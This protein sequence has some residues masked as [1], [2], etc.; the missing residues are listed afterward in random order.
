MTFRRIALA[1]FLIALALV[2]LL[3]PASN[4]FWITQANYISLYTLVVIGLVLL[5]GIAGLISFGQAAFVGMGAY[6]AA[7]LTLTYGISPWLTVWIGLVVTGVAALVLGWITLRMSGHYLPLATI[8][9]GL[10]LFYLLGNLDALGKYDGLLGIPPINFF[11]IALSTG[12]HFFYLVW[13]IVI[14]AAVAVTHLL[15][16]RAGRALR[17]VK[18]GTTM[19]EAMGVDTFRVKV[20]AFVLAAL[21][22]SISG[23]L[24]AHF[25]RTV[26]PSPFGLNMGIE[27]LF[28]AVLGGVG[29]VW[30]ALVGAGVVQILK[31]QLQVWLPRLMGTSGNYEII[32]F[33]ILL[34][35]VLQYA[36]DGLWA[37]IEAVLPR[38]D[39]K[40][41]WA[42]AEALPARPK[43][44]HGQVVLDVRAV[45]KEFGG[46]VAVNDVSF[47]VKAGEILG[48]IGPNG[49]GKSTTFNLVTGV[50]LATRGEVSLLGRR[51]D[52][53]ASRKIARL[54][55]SR[56]F[57]HVKMIGGMTVLENVALGAHL[58][59]RHGVPAAMLRTDRAEERRLMRE[60]EFQLKR[61]GMGE[62]MHEKAGNL[63]LGQQRLMEIARALAAD[64]TL[65]LL[66]EPAAGLRLKEKEGL[67][68]VLRQLRGEGLSILLVE[69]D[70]DL[71]M[72]LVD[73]VVVMEF[74]TKLIEGTPE[75]VQASPAVRAAYLGTEH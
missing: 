42:N 43:P 2:P 75:E 24:F 19:A 22:A 23:W 69:H 59:G 67:A 31:D 63:A 30:G 1:L 11:G 20:T 58:R 45:R 17:A 27:Y 65:L 34:V 44:P 48:L 16:S 10:S 61:I 74:G 51:I 60:A 38:V 6:T 35:L 14:V 41:D 8:A 56:T 36:R 5:T 50:L 71:V 62:L 46:L 15:D 9:W 26:N 72:D 37:F 18:G 13:L 47:D 7:Y 3:T 55:V 39:R 33:G 54:G 49:A 57:Q 4:E 29:Y 68:N 32:V 64:P 12:R 40:V 28:M 52:S 70:M 53:L 73:R 25:Q 66:D 21:L